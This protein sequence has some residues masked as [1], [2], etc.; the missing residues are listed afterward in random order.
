MSRGI[1]NLVCPACGHD[2]FREK[3]FS[4]TI[5]NLLKNRRK[6]TRRMIEKISGLI[7]NNVPTD[8]S[9]TQF[10]YFLVGIKDCEDREIEWGID[11]FYKGRHYN[12]GKGYRY[13]SKIITNRKTNLVKMAANERKM[14]G[15][16][17]PEFNNKRREDEIIKKEK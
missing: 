13:L 2:Y 6:P 1:K 15:S 11:I 9:A 3:D 12:Y 16:S 10:Y 7:R 14:I 5:F 17:P 4:S 8:S